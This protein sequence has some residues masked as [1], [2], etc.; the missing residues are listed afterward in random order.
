[1]KYIYMLSV[2]LLEVLLVYVLRTLSNYIIISIFAAVLLAGIIV[3]LCT[4]EQNSVLK[5][6]GWGMLFGSLVVILFACAIAIFYIR[7]SFYN[8]K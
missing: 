8:T 3:T 7:L 5:N 6:A 1:M 4:K 2:I